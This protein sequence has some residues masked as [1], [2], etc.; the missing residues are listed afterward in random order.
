MIAAV[1]AAL[2][3]A[4]APPG[5]F[6]NSAV[7]T[8]F[9]S[10]EELTT[11][12]NVVVDGVPRDVENSPLL[13]I[14][15]A[16]VTTDLAAVNCFGNAIE[17]R[18]MYTPG[19]GRCE[20]VTVGRTFDLNSDGMGMALP[21]STGLLHL[22][23]NSVNAANLN[24]GTS[25]RGQRCGAVQ[26]DAVQG[27]TSGSIDAG[28]LLLPSSLPVGARCGGGTPLLATF[29]TRNLAPIDA[30]CR[31]RLGAVGA[32]LEL[33]GVYLVDNP[34]ANAVAAADKVAH[35]RTVYGYSEAV[36]NRHPRVFA[37]RSDMAV[38]WM[39]EYLQRAGLPAMPAMTAEMHAA[40]GQYPAGLALSALSQQSFTNMTALFPMLCPER[41]CTS[42]ELFVLPQTATDADMLPLCQPFTTPDGLTHLCTSNDWKNVVIESV[43]YAFRYAMYTLSLTDFEAALASLAPLP[44]VGPCPFREQMSEWRTLQ[45][46]LGVAVAFAQTKDFTFLRG[47]LPRSRLAGAGAPAPPSHWSSECNECFYDGEIAAAGGG[48]CSGVTGSGTTAGTPCSG[49]GV[50]SGYPV[51]NRH[52]P[53]FSAGTSGFNPRDLTTCTPTTLPTAALDAA[54]GCPLFYP[55]PVRTSFFMNVSGLGDFFTTGTGPATFYSGA[56]GFYGATLQNVFSGEFLLN[57]ATSAGLL[58]EPAE[59]YSTLRTTYGRVS[60]DLTHDDVSSVETGQ[61]WTP[62]VPASTC[63]AIQ[64]PHQMWKVLPGND[65]GCLEDN[66]F[67]T[68]Q[69]C[70]A[71]AGTFPHAVEYWQAHN[72]QNANAHWL[73]TVCPPSAMTPDNVVP[74]S[75]DTYTGTVTRVTTG[76]SYMSAVCSGG[77]CFPL[78]DTDA[79]TAAET[80]P[81]F[82]TANFT[83]QGLD[84]TGRNLVSALTRLYTAGAVAPSTYDPLYGGGSA[85]TT[86]CTAGPGACVPYRTIANQSLP[87]CNDPGLASTS[88]HECYL[89]VRD[90]ALTFFFDSNVNLCYACPDVIFDGDTA[91]GANPSVNSTI[92]NITSDGTM[93]TVGDGCAASC[94]GDCTCFSLLDSVCTLHTGAVTVDSTLPGT[95]GGACLIIPLGTG[96]ALAYPP[97]LGILSLAPAGS[98]TPGTAFDHLWILGSITPPLAAVGTVTTRPTTAQLSVFDLTAAAASVAVATAQS[99][100][101]I[102]DTAPEVTTSTTTIPAT[103]G[104]DLDMTRALV[105]SLSAVGFCWVSTHGITA[106]TS[107]GL[108]GLCA[109]TDGLCHWRPGEYGCGNQPHSSWMSAIGP[110]GDVSWRVAGTSNVLTVLCSVSTAQ[111]RM[112]TWPATAGMLPRSMLNDNLVLVNLTAVPLRANVAVATHA[113]ATAWMCGAAPALYT[114]GSVFTGGGRLCT[115]CPAGQVGQCQNATHCASGAPCPSGMTAC[116]RGQYGENVPARAA[117]AGAAA[118]ATPATLGFPPERW[119]YYDSADQ[120]GFVYTQ[121]TA[122]TVID[123]DLCV[124]IGDEVV[125]DPRLLF[126][127]ATARDDLPAGLTRTALNAWCA[128]GAAA[129]ECSVRGTGGVLPARARLCTWDVSTCRLR[130]IL[131]HD[132]EVHAAGEASFTSRT[133]PVVYPTCYLWVPGIDPDTECTHGCV[134]TETQQTISAQLST[135][136]FDATQ[137]TAL[138]FPLIQRAVTAGPALAPGPGLVM[139]D[140]TGVVLRLLNENTTLW[141]VTIGYVGTGGTPV[142]VTVAG[143]WSGTLVSGDLYHFLLPTVLLASGL[144][145]LE[146]GLRLTTMHDLN[147]VNV[148]IQLG[149]VNLPAGTVL[150]GYNASKSTYLGVYPVVRRACVPLTLRIVVNETS[151]AS[152]VSTQ[153]IY[154]R[155]PVDCVML[156]S[157]QESMLLPSIAAL[158]DSGGICDGATGSRLTWPGPPGPSVLDDSNMRYYSEWYRLMQPALMLYGP[159]AADTLE[160]DGT[161]LASGIPNCGAG[162]GCSVC[163][164]ET[165]VIYCTT[166]QSTTV[167]MEGRNPAMAWQYLRYSPAEETEASGTFLYPTDLVTTGLYTPATTTA[168]S[169]ATAYLA[170]PTSQWTEITSNIYTTMTNYCAF[171]FATPKFPDGKPMWCENDPLSLADRIAFCKQYK[172][173]NLVTGTV[174]TTL[175][176]TDI[177]PWMGGEA[178]EYCLIFADHPRYNTAGSLLRTTPP[179]GGSFNGIAMYYVP[180]HMALLANVLGSASVAETLYTNSV[181]PSVTKLLTA[182]NYNKYGDMVETLFAPLRGVDLGNLCTGPLTLATLA[183]V[184]A[185]ITASG[186]DDDGYTFVQLTGTSS[187]EPALVTYTA[188]QTWGVFAEASAEIDF[189]DM[190]FT[191][192]V[193]GYPAT[194]GTAITS[195]AN[196]VVT[197]TRYQVDGANIEIHSLVFDQSLCTLTG[198]VEQTPIV[199]SG[200]AAIDCSVHDVTFKN[201]RVGVAVLGG[202]SIVNTYHELIDATG[203]QVYDATFT[204]TATSTIPVFERNIL[205]VFAR[206][207]GSA[208][209]ATCPAALPQ[210]WVRLPNCVAEYADAGVNCTAIGACITAAA[211]TCCGDAVL[212][213]APCSLGH[214]CT[215]PAPRA[216]ARQLCN[217]A[218][219]V[220]PPTNALT[221]IAPPW[222]AFNGTAVA[223][224]QDW[225]FGGSP[226]YPTTQYYSTFY[227]TLVSFYR[228]VGHGELVLAVS[229]QR[230][231]EAV[232]STLAAPPAPVVYSGSQLVIDYDRSA[233][234][235][236]CVNATTLAIENCSTAGHWYLDDVTGRVHPSQS[237]GVCITLIEGHLLLG[238][239]RPCCVGTEQ[240]AASTGA[241]SS[242][243]TVA[244]AAYA[245]AY[246]DGSAGVYLDLNSTTALELRPQPGVIGAGI[247]MHPGGALLG[248]AMESAA[249]LAPGTY[250]VVA[251]DTSA[252]TVAYDG[253]TLRVVSGGASYRSNMVVTVDGCYGRALV[254]RVWAEPYETGTFTLEATGMQFVNITAYTARSGIGHTTDV[255]PPRPVVSVWLDVG[256]GVSLVILVVLVVGLASI[257]N[258]QAK[259]VHEI[260]G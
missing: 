146:N 169:P 132:Y 142:W 158:F 180:F 68:V 99:L 95:A 188:A 73:C 152:Q 49:D 185:V 90:V 97:T 182:A 200:A 253:T 14:R 209:T 83:A 256:L 128:Q 257:L 54:T 208:M 173:W 153:L 115:D 50:C 141:N 31:C 58:P 194:I 104:R 12:G 223:A 4:A 190:T 11:D 13:F 161:T 114:C 221:C 26:Q 178:G 164:D 91:L 46:P 48:C 129:T 191:T 258:V 236:G 51:A 92:G 162:V 211:L 222:F 212:S 52:G 143:P 112:C 118:T 176:L 195:T 32:V 145:V 147:G 234:A 109:P 122:S 67:Q 33:S 226:W 126:P 25:L 80:S 64:G 84:G 116:T 69:Q 79:A 78:L 21:T 136:E 101:V 43:A 130:E 15:A 220:D 186:N 28:L 36:T 137:G 18:A 214:A 34:S 53:A 229:P 88:M 44:P 22:T 192:A 70:C 151:L 224:V 160:Y 187:L 170:Q 45:P 238:P 167:A 113:D 55:Q 17:W 105:G 231:L 82:S 100:R 183:A 65:A 259:L 133:H 94:T 210:G 166:V 217:V 89:L 189:D 60:G 251:P 172:P 85:A 57:N 156:G 135:N 165:S 5:Y 168:P 227:S 248:V 66:T 87:T 218:A 240:A 81:R 159:G 197:C 213:P 175:T 237:P 119:L 29:A 6:S 254:M 199:F 202:D 35:L 239:C 77:G 59:Q 56:T 127:R 150:S 2:A 154:R 255:A 37:C 3:A 61:M 203:L 110:N 144:E 40:L 140:V 102:T 7:A 131:Q 205:A 252:A 75:S 235:P 163:V 24:S 106:D 250:T 207:I 241:A 232:N 10:G 19:P 246:R 38:F 42:A 193:P 86:G 30:V 230:V 242:I 62:V 125:E 243:V 93:G 103:P 184:H 171:F 16:G 139:Y 23:G 149:L 107:A 206:T 8:A 27:V 123:T 249:C 198:I 215:A 47:G 20:N 225:Q 179:A 157:Q 233:G 108:G 121:Y 98:T 39:L 124:A 148:G 204:Y 41:P 1:I 181:E 63:P 260:E 244:P 174:V 155:S 247:L 72:P 76:R 96:L 219:C 134:V 196:N 228:A 9:D 120:W 177:C 138:Y 74:T 111:G 201:A 71:W 117:L 216:N 245:Y